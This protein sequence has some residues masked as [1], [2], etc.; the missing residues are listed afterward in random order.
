MISDGADS[1]WVID[2]GLGRGRLVPAGD[3]AGRQADRRLRGR[4]PGARGAAAAGAAACETVRGPSATG[5]VPLDLL[6]LFENP[7]AYGWDGY[8]P[9]RDRMFR[10]RDRGDVGERY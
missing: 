8:L 5:G 3:G 9:W 10:R 4:D 2:E 7:G 1:V 6:A